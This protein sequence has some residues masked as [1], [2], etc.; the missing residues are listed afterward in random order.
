MQNILNKPE[1]KSRER[2][3][4]ISNTIHV[5]QRRIQ[6]FRSDA[7]LYMENIL[8]ADF[9]IYS[10]LKKNNSHSC[11]IKIIQYWRKVFTNG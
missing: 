5:M 1:K 3:K 2:V 8:T 10:R 4:S 6:P 7:F 11:K 9:P